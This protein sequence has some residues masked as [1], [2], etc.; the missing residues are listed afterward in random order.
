MINNVFEHWYLPPVISDASGRSSNDSNYTQADN[1]LFSI[2]YV[3][4]NG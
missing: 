2:T 3:S 1:V 4:S